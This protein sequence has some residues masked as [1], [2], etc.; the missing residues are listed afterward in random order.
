MAEKIKMINERVAWGLQESERND[1][2]FYRCSSAFAAPTLVL[3]IRSMIPVLVFVKIARSAS[4]TL[5]RCP[6]AAVEPGRSGLLKAGGGVK[7]LWIWSS[8]LPCRHL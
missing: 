7:D 3:R 1:S 2:S 6:E 4:L 8:E 5:H